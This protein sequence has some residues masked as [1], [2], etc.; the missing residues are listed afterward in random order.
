[1]SIIIEGTDHVGKTTLANKLG[2]KIGHMSKPSTVYCLSDYI[3]RLCNTETQVWDRFHLGGIVYGQMLGLHPSN[4]T[5]QEIEMLHRFM[6]WRGDVLVVITAE[7]E[8]LASRLDTA[9]K[10]EMFS[11]D[12]ILKAN[13]GFE[14]L[15]EAFGL[16][17]MSYRVTKE[18]PFLDDQ[19][20]R[21]ILEVHGGR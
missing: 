10:V 9:G 21:A 2:T 6:D 19:A 15:V 3:Q 7:P 20:V 8:F 5:F 16:H 4:I 14:V 17:G 13:T 18:R 1:M 12:M 11:R